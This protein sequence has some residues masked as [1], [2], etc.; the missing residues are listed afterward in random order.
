MQKL[1]LVLYF[2]LILQVPGAIS[3][4]IHPDSTVIAMHELKA[5]QKIASNIINPTKDQLYELLKFGLWEKALESTEK[6]KLKKSEKQLLAASYYVYQN[7]F[8]K[9]QALVDEVLKTE[10]NNFEALVAKANLEI[11]AWRL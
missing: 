9:A 8:F 11:Q 6:S 5:H 1:A 4:T 3:Q 2:V 7:M 10:P